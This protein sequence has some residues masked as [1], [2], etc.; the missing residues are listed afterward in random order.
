MTGILHESLEASN[1]GHCAPGGNPILERSKAQ[2]ATHRAVPSSEGVLVGT[3]ARIAAYLTMELFTAVFVTA[4][5]VRQKTAR[6]GRSYTAL[7]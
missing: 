3:G 5:A 7:Q 1:M 4:L 2:R 6:A